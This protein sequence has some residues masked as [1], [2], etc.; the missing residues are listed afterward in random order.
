MNEKERNRVDKHIYLHILPLTNDEIP[1]NKNKKL[2]ETVNTMKKTKEVT[3]ARE[4][5]EKQF[6]KIEKFDEDMKPEPKKSN[7]NNS[8]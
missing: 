4:E 5:I 8:K 1:K 3:K 2:T 7:R 6:E